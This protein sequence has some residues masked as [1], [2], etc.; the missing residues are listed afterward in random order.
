MRLIDPYRWVACS[1]TEFGP[2][3]EQ[4]HL[5]RKGA[6][7]TYCA[8]SATHPDIWRANRRKPKCETCGAAEARLIP[9]GAST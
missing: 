7:T 5:A 2:V 6:L 4:R 9:P 8:H 1:A 3:G